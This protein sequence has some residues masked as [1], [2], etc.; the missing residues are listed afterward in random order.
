[1]GSLAEQLPLW[2]NETTH[3]SGNPGEMFGGD[4]FYNFGNESGW[5]P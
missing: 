1:M 3:N 4:V 2:L 5:K